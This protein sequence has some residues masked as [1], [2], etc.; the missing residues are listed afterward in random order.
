M[1]LP[2]ELQARA[3]DLASKQSY[4]PVIL[5][6]DFCNGLAQ[7]RSHGRHRR[8]SIGVSSNPRDVALRSRFCVPWIVDE[9]WQTSEQFLESLLDLGRILQGKGFLSVSSEQF[10]EMGACFQDQ[11]GQVFTVP[12][13]FEV[14]RSLSNKEVQAKKATEAGLSVPTTVSV[15]RHGHVDQADLRR[16]TFPVFVRARDESKRFYAEQGLQGVVVKSP[17]ELTSVIERFFDYSLL[18]Q[19]FISDLGVKSFCVS[20]IVLQDGRVI[21][22]TYSVVRNVRRFGSSSMGKSQPPSHVDL[23]VKKFLD[24]TDYVGPFDILFLR[25]EGTE[26]SF[27]IEMN[28]RFWKS[29]GLAQKCGLDL[30][31]LQV[32][33]SLG[34]PLEVSANLDYQV[35]VRWWLIFTDL[36]I[37]WRQWRAGQLTWNEFRGSIGFPFV[38][39]I[40]SWDDPLPEIYNF[41]RLRWLLPVS[42]RKG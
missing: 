32:Q 23:A 18:V 38:S 35:G 33:D 37:C 39:G 15:E 22:Y 4:V 1:R 6:V 12:V 21:T 19:E 17:Q 29:H 31:I 24:L 3:Q 11:L 14:I 20:G 40:G 5:P 10:V 25:P 41:L 16:L 2:Q 42:S 36:V 34:E 26:T 27:F 28:M 30:P 13:D 9:D 7:L 8:R